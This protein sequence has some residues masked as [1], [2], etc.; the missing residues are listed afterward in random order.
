M[1][2]IRHYFVRKLLIKR[3]FIALTV[4]ASNAAMSGNDSKN[5]LQS[6]PINSTSKIITQKQLESAWS[7]MPE[8]ALLVQ[9]EKANQQQGSRW[10]WESPSLSVDYQ[11]EDNSVSTLDSGLPSQW[12]IGLEL[13]IAGPSLWAIQSN[14]QRFQRKLVNAEQQMLRWRLA[15]ELEQLAWSIKLNDLQVKLMKQKY[16]FSLDHVD[17]ISKLERLGERPQDEVLQ[18]RQQLILAQSEYLQV[19]Q[20]LQQSEM[21]W[22]QLTGLQ[23][24][25][26][27]MPALQHI[28]LLNQI[29]TDKLSE[30]S[31]GNLVQSSPL[32]LWRRAQLDVVKLD[33]QQEKGRS[34]APTVRLGLLQIDELGSQE[35][36]NSWQ[37]GITIPLGSG[38]VGKWRGGYRAIGNAEV[39]YEKTHRMLMLQQQKLQSSIKTKMLQLSVI[40]PLEKD[41]KAI[42]QPRYN[43]YKQGMISN[44][45]WRP[46]QQSYWDTQQQVS[47]VEIELRALQ[48]QLNHLQGVMQ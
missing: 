7:R 14:M 25:S 48:S 19:Q 3:L 29:S 41:L 38:S 24:N 43:A 21:R 10:W 5:S 27:S 16:Q 11:A 39:Q 26:S 30:N 6:T 36:K 23:F 2:S 28:S 47:A 35:Q 40:K 17:W 12:E 9:L 13:P 33:L 42:F 32:L 4:L 22:Q 18:A 37:L 8:Q 31:A 45:E 46:L 20:L 44:L 15:G 1:I 34:G